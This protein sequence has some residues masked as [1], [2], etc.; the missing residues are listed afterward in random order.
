M[1][2]KNTPKDRTDGFIVLDTFQ[3]FHQKNDVFRRSWWD[4]R[5]R[6]PKSRLF[7]ETYREPLK[8]WR[9]ADGFTQKDYALRNAAWH[10]SD[11][12]TELKEDQDRREGFTDAFTL[13]RD[14]AGQKIELGSPEEAAREI[15]MVAKT[16]GAGLVGI[17]GYDER[18]EYAGKFSDLNTWL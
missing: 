7:Y 14:V 18:W 8:T 11:L 16:L 4:E 1:A 3:R 9:K 5:I 15:K 12:F 2:N 6:S 13:Q 10:V 17:T